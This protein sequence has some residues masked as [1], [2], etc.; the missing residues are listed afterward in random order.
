M[1]TYITILAVTFALSGFSQAL[2]EPN[3]IAFDGN[4]LVSYFDGEVKKGNQNYSYKYEGFNLQFASRENLEKFKSDP[5][6]YMP[7]YNGHCAVALVRGDLI[8]PDFNFYKIQ[9]GELLFFEVRAFFNGRTAWD[10]DPDINKIV[11][12]KK[13][14]DLE[15]DN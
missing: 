5:E 10:K 14:R 15:K 12:D 4:D 13:F 1:K 3:E 2:F 7:A 8:K 9:D 11:A 6:K